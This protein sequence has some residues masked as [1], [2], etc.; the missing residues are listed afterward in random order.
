SALR[1]R[2]ARILVE[3]ARAETR[4][5]QEEFSA[6]LEAEEAAK[7]EA[8]LL[9]PNLQ[10]TIPGLDLSKSVVYG[11]GSNGCAKGFV[12][13][14][15]IERYLNGVYKFAA[16]A[17]VTFA[18]VLIMIGGAQYAVGSAAGSIEAGKKRITNAMIGLV[19]VLSV[20]AILTFVNPDIATLGA[21]K[22]EVVRHLDDTSVDTLFGG[23]RIHPSIAEGKLKELTSNKYLINVGRQGIH[24]DIWEDF[25]QVA[26]SYYDK[27]SVCTDRNL[28]SWKALGTCEE[29]GEGQKLKITSGGRSQRRQAELYFDQCLRDKNGIGCTALVCNPFPRDSSGPIEEY[30]NKKWR[31]KQNV[32]E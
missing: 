27:T 29:R 8:S 17:G 6:Q 19:L 3:H 21:L 1:S 20:H 18:I 15:T 5:T 28:W 13:A 11:T 32:L 26:K 30:E 22:L 31:V 4:P 16:G 25:P 7:L 12:C 9:T 14:N 23:E 24:E 10:V 2:G